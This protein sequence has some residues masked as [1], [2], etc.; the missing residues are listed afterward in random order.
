M[1][2]D[3]LVDSAIEFSEPLFKLFWDYWYYI[4][5]IPIVII[6]YYMAQIWGFI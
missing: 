1:G 5:V 6:F 4:I 3:E 2:I